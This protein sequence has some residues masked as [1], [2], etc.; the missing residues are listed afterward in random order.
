[1][2][3]SM[4][5]HF[6]SFASSK[7]LR[8]QDRFL[9]TYPAL[10]FPEVYLLS[11]GFKNFYETNAELCD[12]SSYRPMLDPKYLE[13]LKAFRVKSKCNRKEYRKEAANGSDRDSDKK[14]WTKS[15][16]R[17]NFC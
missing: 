7:F 5:F 1:M 12:P 13:D 17:L 15:R 11:G 6:F 9:N 10:H 16:S 8:H 4:F 2:S 3:H 14:R